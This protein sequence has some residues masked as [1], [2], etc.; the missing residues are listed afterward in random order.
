[1]RYMLLIY[2]KEDELARAS[3]TDV[4]TIRNGHWAVME[5]AQRKGILQGAEPLAPTETATTVRRVDGTTLTTDGPFAETK[6]QL[7]GYYI[8]DCKNLDEAIEWAEK[9]P[10]GC[11]GL[12]GCVEIRPLPGVPTREEAAVGNVSTGAGS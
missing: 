6:E 1:M 2:T 9:I 10:T 4:E 11:G 3:R 7:A 8:L 5:E 12:Q